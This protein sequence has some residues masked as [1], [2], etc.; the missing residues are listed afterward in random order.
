MDCF[1]F[2]PESVLVLTLNPLKR[3][4]DEGPLVLWLPKRED[5]V[6]VDQLLAA[7]SVH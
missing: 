4:P 3:P 7:W 2:A 1:L 6:G 5:M